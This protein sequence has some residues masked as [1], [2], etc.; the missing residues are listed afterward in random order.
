VKRKCGHAAATGAGS[1][2]AFRFIHEVSLVECP[3]ICV[4]IPVTA[5]SKCRAAHIFG[6]AVFID[7]GSP[8][9]HLFKGS[10]RAEAPCTNLP[11]NRDT[12]ASL[13]H[14]GRPRK[15]TAAITNQLECFDATDTMDVSLFD[16]RVS[17][18]VRVRWRQ[19]PGPNT[20][21]AATVGPDVQHTCGEVPSRITHHR[22]Q[23]NE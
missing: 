13:R 19:H 4:L 11:S 9:A 14:G 17:F 23:P 16:D 12:I 7:F 18:D 15:D 22:K 10:R 20:H 1:E 3:Q 5:R 6:R 21:A 2:D 8:P